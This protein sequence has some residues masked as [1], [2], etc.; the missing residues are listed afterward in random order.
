[1]NEIEEVQALLALKPSQEFLYARIADLDPDN[2][3]FEEADETQKAEHGRAWW[4]ARE[5]T[6]RGL[7]CGNKK[8][9]V[10]GAGSIA[11]DT[12]ALVLQIVG[13]KFGMSIAT[14]LTA[15][16]IQKLVDGWCRNEGA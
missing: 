15:I 5:Q 9:A 1:M 14:F 10:D 3:G 11:K 4:Q 16:V 2:L 8:L 6:I 12:I 13:A 7:I